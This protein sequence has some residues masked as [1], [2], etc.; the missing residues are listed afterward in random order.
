MHG[1]DGRR[2]L[3]TLESVIH[4]TGCRSIHSIALLAVTRAYQSYLALDP[5]S[6]RLEHSS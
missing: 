6:V 2:L 1:G 4:S 3:A 5:S